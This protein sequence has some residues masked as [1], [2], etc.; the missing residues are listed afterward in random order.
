MYKSNAVVTVPPHTNTTQLNTAKFAVL[1]KIEAQLP[2]AI[3]K[4]EWE[5]LKEGKDPRVYYP[6]SH[7][8]LLIPWIFGVI[9]IVLFF[10]FPY[11]A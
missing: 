10:Y 7:I 1:H 8:E 9:Y 2:L 3:Y 4:Y 5:I 11:H 6:F